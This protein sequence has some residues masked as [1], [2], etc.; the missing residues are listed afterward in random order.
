MLTACSTS[1]DADSTSDLA[2]TAVSPSSQVPLTREV[3]LTCGGK[4]RISGTLDYAPT[5]LPLAQGGEAT[6]EPQT[7][8]QVVQPWEDMAGDSEVVIEEAGDRATAFVRRTDGT[9]SARL[10]LR[11]RDD[12]DWF[13]DLFDACQRA[14]P[15][16]TESG[17]SPQPG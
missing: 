3:A 7:L 1:V 11:D 6:A 10:E 5:G 16:N 8:R 12:D 4:K 14:V 2:R 17:N 13:I 15:W 9:V